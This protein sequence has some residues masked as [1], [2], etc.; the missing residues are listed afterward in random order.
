MLRAFYEYDWVSLRRYLIDTG[1]MSRENGWYWRTGGPVDEEAA[2]V[3]PRLPAIG[4]SW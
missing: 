1:L 3:R 2:A 4:G